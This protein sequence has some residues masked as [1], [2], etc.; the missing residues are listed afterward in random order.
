[1]YVDMVQTYSPY[2]H[3][4]INEPSTF[5]QGMEGYFTEYTQTSR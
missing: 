3:M 2:K 5:G 4:K 1:M